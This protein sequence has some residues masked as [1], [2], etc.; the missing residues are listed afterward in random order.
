MFL[1]IVLEKSIQGS[2]NQT[3]FKT[4]VLGFLSR[5]REISWANCM[6]CLSEK[7]HSN[8]LLFLTSS[9]LFADWLKLKNS[10]LK[11][12]VKPTIVVFVRVGTNV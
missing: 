10:G 12:F 9:P 2:Y 3:C 8:L 6:D 7:S 5:K 4:W 1:Q 11:A